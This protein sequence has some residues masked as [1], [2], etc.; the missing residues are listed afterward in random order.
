MSIFIEL[1]QYI[2]LIFVTLYIKQRIK[3]FKFIVPVPIP[4]IGNLYNPHTFRTINYL[5][6]CFKK[7]GSIF[8]FWVGTKPMIV[9]CEPKIIRKI[10]SNDRVFIKGK[11]YTD[12]FSFVFGQGLVTSNNVK[13]K[14]DIR[15]LGK[16][17]N[18]NNSERY[19]D[20]INICTLN[21]INDELMNTLNNNFDIQNFFH[22]L[23]L[24]IFGK[25]YLGIDY[26]SNN[27]IKIAS[28]LSEDI[29][30]GSHLIGKHIIL[31]VPLFQFLPS[32]KKLNSVKKDV[33]NHIEN[34]INDRIKQN[35]NGLYPNDILQELISSKDMY[36]Q[37]S[38]KKSDIKEHLRT[39]LAAGH[40]TTSYLGCYTCY[41]LAKHPNIQNKLRFEINQNIK[42]NYISKDDISNLKYV[43]CV[44]KEV[45]RL[46]TII[47]FITRTSIKK[48]SYDEGNLIIPKNS[49]ILIPLCIMN[50]NNCI[51]D[52]PSEFIPERFNDLNSN[53][54]PNMGYL[55]FG[56]GSRTCVGNTFAI[57]EVSII[58]T[59]IVKQF[60]ISVSD[61][62]KPNI[63]SGISLISSNGI[64]LRLEKI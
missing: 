16:Y 31:N 49:D 44:I 8:T 33:D 50:R 28:K 56:Y 58:I 30:I 6:Y 14:K 40:D 61:N 13:H 48:Y 18:K 24:N 62:F 63:I 21:L 34:I 55:P 35:K 15:C 64:E 46:F 47:P 4:L 41:L 19:C 12:K 32:V 43:N 3:Y 29:K 39:L 22:R 2:I 37:D 57:L 52:K 27:N 54:N 23:T 10:L 1:I 36:I 7:Y 20:I 59:Q 26:S 42:S 51:W 11:D 25:V 5:S 45:L 17:F 60:N 38:N 9:I 53:N